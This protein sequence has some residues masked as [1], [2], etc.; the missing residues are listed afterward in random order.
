MA[1]REDERRLIMGCIESHQNMIKHH[2]AQILTLRVQLNEIEDA[3]EM[4][5]L[6]IKRKK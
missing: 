5:M 6:D 1:L 2:R 3:P 4:T